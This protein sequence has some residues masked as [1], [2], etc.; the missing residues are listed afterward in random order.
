MRQLVILNLKLQKYIK[1][2]KD[3]KSE[4]IFVNLGDKCSVIS[5]RGNSKYDD[6]YVVNNMSKYATEIDKYFVL[7]PSKFDGVTINGL[8]ENTIIRNIYLP[9]TANYSELITYKDIFIYAEKYNINVE[10]YDVED[11]V[12][13][14]NGVSFC[15][16]GNDISAIASSD[17]YVEISDK[18]VFYVYGGATQKRA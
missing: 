2:F 8:M 6:F 14:C 9:K 17:N 10:L 16:I 15:K 18:K 3:G 11:I 12:E 4:F 1:Y 13:I 5:V 7:E